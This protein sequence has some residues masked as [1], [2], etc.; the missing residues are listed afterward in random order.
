M[1]LRIEAGRIRLGGREVLGGLDVHLAPPAL[2][3]IV[4]PNGSG[5]STLLRALAG[6][7]PLAGGRAWIGGRPLGALSRRELARRVAYLPQGET[8]S[9]PFPVEDVVR[10]GRYPHLG[11]FRAEGSDDELAVERALRSTDAL[12]LRARPVTELSGGERQRVLLARTLATEAPVLLLDEPAAN[13][14]VRHA[15]DLLDLLAGEAASGRAVAV[16]L[17]DLNLAWRF[18]DF[19][20][21]LHAGGIAAQGA[22]GEVL[23]SDRVRAAFGVETRILPSPEGDQLVFERSAR[24]RAS[25][26]HSRDAR[27]QRDV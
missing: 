16:A 17:H 13:L 19:V 1:A 7:L 5:K 10:M 23:R 11:L 12:H 18:C 27:R 3:G 25:A 20:W 21:L 9:A 26:L 6:I 4:G 22:P 15:L 8:L 14:D 2:T 24:G